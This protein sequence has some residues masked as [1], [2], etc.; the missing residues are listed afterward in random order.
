M[1]WVLIEISERTFE[2]GVP[3]CCLEQS[4]KYKHEW[5]ANVGH[6]ACKRALEYNCLN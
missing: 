1:P 4:E 3:K 6:D 2:S 5:L